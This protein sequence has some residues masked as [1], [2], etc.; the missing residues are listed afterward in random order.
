[1]VVMNSMK[2]AMVPTRRGSISLR[3][4]AGSTEKL[5]LVGRKDDIY[6]EWSISPATFG[7]NLQ[8]SLSSIELTN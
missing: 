3:S 2:G 6:A 1:M 7:Q 8:V 5:Y 4:A